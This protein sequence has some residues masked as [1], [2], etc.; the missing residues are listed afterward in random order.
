MEDEENW[1]AATIGEL[2]GTGFQ[3]LQQVHDA[4]S[5]VQEV[6]S[7]SASLA[8][9]IAAS[10]DAQLPWLRQVLASVS[11]ARR[12]PNPLHPR[13]RV[14]QTGGTRVV[15]LCPFISFFLLL[16]VSHNPNSRGLQRENAGPD[17]FGVKN[18]ISG[19]NRGTSFVSDPFSVS[20]QS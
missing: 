20:K 3:T 5:Y 19:T 4:Q 7:D 16:Q 13:G 10:E 17:K 9:Y 11:Q 8:K 1:V 18:H 6:A 15:F 12:P 14:Y 2:Q